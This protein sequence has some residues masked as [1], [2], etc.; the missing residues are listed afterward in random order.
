M[1]TRIRWIAHNTSRL[2]L[3]YG[4]LRTAAREKSSLSQMLSCGIG[5]YLSSSSQRH[6]YII[7]IIGKAPL[8][9]AQSISHGILNTLHSLI[10]TSATRF[11]NSSE[12]VPLL[13]G[14]YIDRY[15][16]SPFGSKT[17]QLYPDPGTIVES[18]HYGIASHQAD[19]KLFLRRVGDRRMTFIQFDHETAVGREEQFRSLCEYADVFHR[20]V[21]KSIGIILVLQYDRSATFAETAL[22]LYE[23]YVAQADRSVN[24]IHQSGTRRMADAFDSR[25]TP[26]LIFLA[27]D[28]TSLPGLPGAFDGK[29][30]N[31]ITLADIPSPFP[32]SESTQPPAPF[33]GPSEATD[34]ISHTP[35]MYTCRSG[36]A[37]EEDQTNSYMN[38]LEMCYT[39]L[40]SAPST[41][42][43]EPSSRESTPPSFMPKHTASMLPPI[44]PAK[45]FAMP[46][47]GLMLPQS[48]FLEGQTPSF[49]DFTTTHVSSSAMTHESITGG[50]HASE[51][52]ICGIAIPGEPYKA[53]DELK[54]YVDEAVERTRKIFADLT[55]TDK[56]N[57]TL[58]SW[59]VQPFSVSALRGGEMTAGYYAGINWMLRAVGAERTRQSRLRSAVR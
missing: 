43:S 35:T 5:D 8:T 44:P 37:F 59:F 50:H 16:P 28:E 46:S 11:H 55:E 9:E 47:A 42:P 41:L 21:D 23:T 32:S 26:L 2:K 20:I 51:K 15:E 1:I 18:S 24:D 33:R 39:T 29:E 22:R 6:R 4:V 34:S 31:L 25:R 17:S 36:G 49:D 19:C 54:A 10:P 57:G 14:G 56:R 45:A 53:E 52:H 7:S 3:A 12:C 58:R 40:P 13:R 38:E 48:A 27:I 30:D